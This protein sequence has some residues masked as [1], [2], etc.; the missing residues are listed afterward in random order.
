MKPTPTAV[1]NVDSQVGCHER[2]VPL[3]RTSGFFKPSP[4]D[5]PRKGCF[6]QT[7]FA[8]N[9]PTFFKFF[10]I[11]IMNWCRKAIAVPGIRNRGLG[12]YCS[13][14]HSRP[15]GARDVY[16]MTL[17]GSIILCLFDICK[18]HSD[19]VGW[20]LEKA[21]GECLVSIDDSRGNTPW[22]PVRYLYCRTGQDFLELSSHKG[23]PERSFA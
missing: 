9:F 20:K 8:G 12:S 15:S 3:L 6:P 2:R 19:R 17:L 13:A 5:L 18:M 4:P 23:C 11:Y 7:Y 1:D 10:G 14:I 21:A 16:T 22:K